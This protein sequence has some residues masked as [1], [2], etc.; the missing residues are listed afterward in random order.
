MCLPWQQWTETAV[1]FDYVGISVFHSCVAVVVIAA[2]VIIV[3]AD[4]WQ[5]ISKWRLLLSE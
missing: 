2:V 5:S 4:I 3:V 1:R